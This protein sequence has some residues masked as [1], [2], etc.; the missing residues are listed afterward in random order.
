MKI[1]NVGPDELNEYELERAGEEE[2]EWLV[3]FYEDYG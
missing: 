1:Y 3:V 2:F